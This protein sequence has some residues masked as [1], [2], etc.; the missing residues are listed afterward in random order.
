MLAG[1][2]IG[3]RDQAIGVI[4][5]KITVYSMNKKEAVMASAILWL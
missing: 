1:S 2:I 4:L 5:C 3:A